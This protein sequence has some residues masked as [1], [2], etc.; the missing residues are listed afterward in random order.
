MARAKI[1]TQMQPWSSFW[2]ALFVTAVCVAG[3]MSACASPHRPATNRCHVQGDWFTFDVQGLPPR[4]RFHGL[5]PTRF[6]LTAGLWHYSRPNRILAGPVTMHNLS[7]ASGRF[8]AVIDFLAGR[9]PRYP[10]H[11]HSYQSVVD[12]NQRGFWYGP[13][14]IGSKRQVRWTFTVPAADS[15]PVLRGAGHIV[16]VYDE[17]ALILSPADLIALPIRGVPLAGEPGGGWTAILGHGGRFPIRAPPGSQRPTPRTRGLRR[18]GQ[19]PEHGQGVRR[20]HNLPA[21]QSPDL[22]SMRTGRKQDQENHCH[23]WRQ[24]QRDG[25]GGPGSQG[26]RH[27][28]ALLAR[29]W[30]VRVC[31]SPGQDLRLKALGQGPLSN[32]RDGLLPR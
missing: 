20:Q 19:G 25:R 14:P 4:I 7:H 31:C 17:P 32:G 5:C 30:S 3:S 15:A 2:A 28:M 22:A 12:H 8:V 13:M 11:P 6:P 29:P 27:A 1:P 21:T 23:D 10:A 16:A 18:L 24:G 26:A 9:D